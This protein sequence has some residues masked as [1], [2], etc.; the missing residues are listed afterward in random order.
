MKL[1]RMFPVRKNPSKYQRE[2]CSTDE[3]LKLQ[4]NIW[5]LVGA[6]VRNVCSVYAC[7]C[8]CAVWL[9]NVG[10]AQPRDEI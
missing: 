4:R 1:V 8:M 3:D 2:S 6:L 5:Q 10:I 9:T 7:M